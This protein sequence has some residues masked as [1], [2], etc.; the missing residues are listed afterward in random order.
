MKK[1]ENFMLPEH[2]NTLYEKEAISSISLTKDVANKIN[3]LVAAY[4][5]LSRVDLEWKQTQEGTI[6]KGVLYMKDNLINSLNDLMNVLL[7]NGYIDSRLRE[8]TSTLSAQLNNLLGMVKE[9]TTSMD[10]EVID[11][12]L[13]ANGVNYQNAGEALRTQIAS[14]LRAVPSYDEN[15]YIDG[16]DGTVKPYNRGDAPHYFATHFIDV[17]ACTV[18]T[19]QN[20]VG[21]HMSPTDRSGYAFYDKGYN[22]ISYGTTYAQYQMNGK[23]L[24]SPI[25]L[26]V[27]H[28]AAYF[29]FTALVNTVNEVYYSTD[30]AL[31][32]VLNQIES[33]LQTILYLPKF[34]KNYYLKE[35]KTI[36]YGGSPSDHKFRV[37]DFLRVSG[38]DSIMIN[39]PDANILAASDVSGFAFYDAEKN[40]LSH[41]SYV[42]YYNR[43]NNSLSNKPVF[44]AVPEGAVYFRY[45]THNDNHSG[46]CVTP[47][48]VFRNNLSVVD[49]PLQE[50]HREAKYAGVF[51]S[52]A[53]IGDSLSSGCS[54]YK[55]GSTTLVIDDQT[56]S[57]GS[58]MSRICGNIYKSFSRGGLTTGGW[59]ESTF[60]TEIMSEKC[61]A[62][63][64]ALGHNDRSQSVQLS[65]FKSNYSSIIAKV[66][67]SCRNAKIFVITDP[68][69]EMESD[70][71]NAIIRELSEQENVYLIDM[72]KYGRHLFEK[73]HI[74]D[75]E[76]W[77]HYNA[78]GYHE[79]AFMVINYVDFI[80][81]NNMEEFMQVEFIGTQY[82]Y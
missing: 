11:I 19:I 65:T 82:T 36:K 68:M 61:E 43:N 58:Y 73:L 1:I 8:Q 21:E 38:C 9:G 44:L 66:K 29:R 79:I 31:N 80:I 26:S 23:N 12:R 81:E 55:Q 50:L 33:I 32:T 25:T 7:S 51:T 16:T 52:F 60:S 63:F 76:R 42:S 34:T 18:I 14:V 72:Y 62:Y 56:H 70:G 13:G 2:T 41:E 39:P 35:G 10:S 45:S 24:S 74:H 15:F 3:E 37:S 46:I 49:E 53:V 59:L 77:G 28:G 27:P 47:F 40:I 54:A 6:R 5:E 57:W 69:E 20:G 78:L 4:N 48:D 75:M 30:A 17:K 67:Q 71:Y 64:I 22:P